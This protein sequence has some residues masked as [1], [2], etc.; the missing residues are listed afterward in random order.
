MRMQRRCAG[1]DVHVQ[2]IPGQQKFARTPRASVTATCQVKRESAFFNTDQSQTSTRVLI[3]HLRHAHA[4]QQTFEAARNFECLACEAATYPRVTVS[5]YRTQEARIHTSSA[6]QT[7]WFPYVVPQHRAAR[8]WQTRMC[9][10][11]RHWS[12]SP[13]TS[14]DWT[15]TL[16]KRS[17]GTDPGKVF[18]ECFG[19]TLCALLLFFVQTKKTRVMSVNHQAG[20]R[21]KPALPLST[22]CS[23]Q[24]G[25][26]WSKK[27]VSMCCVCRT[28]VESTAATGTSLFTILRTESGRVRSLSQF[29]KQKQTG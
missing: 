4:T 16:L 13:E 17:F 3:R 9:F 2:R 29:S 28:P 5:S 18:N 21:L 11:A 23:G 14:A 12:P 27:W 1:G 7:R 6:D 15:K 25:V 20:A 8:F 19:P 22:R 10:S 24:Q 26:S